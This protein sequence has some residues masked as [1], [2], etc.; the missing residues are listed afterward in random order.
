MITKN[1]A[2][3]LPTNPP[4]VIIIITKFTINTRNLITPW[5]VFP[6]IQNG[7]LAMRIFVTECMHEPLAR[8]LWTMSHRNPLLDI[9]F[10]VLVHEHFDI[11]TSFV[12][13]SHL[14][15]FWR[16]PV[17][18]NYVCLSPSMCYKGLHHGPV[19]SV[20]I[21]LFETSSILAITLLVPQEPT[22][23]RGRVT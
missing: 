15:G 17:C 21:I 5:L 22:T 9:L 19:V 8:G 11:K 3:M 18:T 2:A 16:S 14:Q 12:I 10:P 6:C 20:V 7:V 13:S 1:T 23:L 4:V